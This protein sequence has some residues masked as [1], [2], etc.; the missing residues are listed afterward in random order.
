MGTNICFFNINNLF[1]RY[2]FGRTYP[3]D[4]RQTSFIADPAFGFLPPNQ[5]AY[6][7]P[8][9]PDQTEVTSQAIKAEGLPDVLCLCEVESILALRVFN[10]MFFGGHYPYAIL[11]DSYDLRQIDVG[12]LSTKEIISIR[13]HIDDLDANGRR[14]FS[15]DC[16]EITLALNKSGSQRLTIFLNHFKSKFVDTR[17]KTPA[18]I[19]AETERSDRRRQLQAEAVRDILKKRYPGSHYHTRKF[20]V[21]G[22]FN[23]Q[24]DSP[25]L[26]PLL[27]QADL[28]NP[29]EDLPDSER[30]TY[31]YGSRNRASQID[32]ILLSPALAEAALQ[33]NS[34]PRIERRG[35]G[36]QGFYATGNMKPLTTRIFRSDSDPDPLRVN[37]AFPR[38][39]T[40][41][42][43][44]QHA[45]DH[46]PIFFEI[47]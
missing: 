33:R 8:Y 40:V 44:G 38:F 9:K 35:L 37:F 3:G 34:L 15:R 21:V 7:Q 18:Q 11:L 45:S 47:P 39:E 16:L 13:T 4:V 23:D 42:D 36:F 29:V 27:N 12:I 43:T 6:F 5:N 10:D 2:R 22:D 19:Q 24:P 1:L 17:N 25:A 32:Y 14:I 41:I 31:W 28:Y 46:C 26:A 30:W 20:M